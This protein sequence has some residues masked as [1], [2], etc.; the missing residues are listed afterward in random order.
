MKVSWIIFLSICGTET[1]PILHI[2]C[3]ENQH[4]HFSLKRPRILIS[5]MAPPLTSTSEIKTQRALTEYRKFTCL[6]WASSK[7]W[8]VIFIICW[9]ISPMSCFLPMATPSSPWCAGVL[10]LHSSSHGSYII[11][12]LHYSNWWDLTWSRMHQSRWIIHP[13]EKKKKKKIQKQR[14]NIEILDGWTLDSS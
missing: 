13:I 2:L 1:S 9:R 12:V 6:A 8:S 14:V 10:L 3:T 11:W 7:D 5:F 4:I